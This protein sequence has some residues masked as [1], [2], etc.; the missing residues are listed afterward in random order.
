MSY[1]CY[2]MRFYLGGAT[3]S[4]RLCTVEEEKNPIEVCKCFN[5]Q[6]YFSKAIGIKFTWIV[7]IKAESS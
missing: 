7:T 5:I 4:E 3:E 1:P 6:V 2:L